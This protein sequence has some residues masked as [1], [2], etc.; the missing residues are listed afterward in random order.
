MQTSYSRHLTNLWQ[1]GIVA[2]LGGSPCLAQA[3]TLNYMAGSAVTRTGTYTDLGTVGTV[4]TT[5]NTDDANS[6]VQTPG[7]VFN[8]NGTAYTSFI[9]NTN[10]FIK[11]GN[12][13]PAAADFITYA[14]DNAGGPV[15][16]P[17][18]T[19]LLMPFNTDLTAGNGGTT[20]YRMSTSGVIPNRVC[21]IQWKNVKDKPRP[22]SASSATLVAAQF[23]NLSFQLKIYETTNNIEFVYGPS[24]AGVASADD[25][26]FVNVGL[27]GSGSG[28]NQVV[29]AQ[30]ASVSSWSVTS[31]LNTAYPTAGNTHNVRG[32]L[33]PDIGRTYTFGVPV[34][35]DAS[36]A[37]IQGFGA[38][39]QPGGNPLSIRAVVRNTGTS[40]LSNLVVS[41]SVSGA[42]S[43]PVMTQTVPTLSSGNSTVVTYTGIRF[44]ANGTNTVTVTVPNDGNLSNNT[45][46]QTLI[47]SPTDFSYIIPSEG[48]YNG[49]GVTPGNESGFAAKFTLNTPRDITAVRAFI[50]DYAATATAGSTI[51]Q[52]VYGVVVDA[53]SG[54]IL[55]RSPN[56]VVT[57][58]AANTL[59]TF[60]L[61]SPVT[62]PAGDF[63]VGMIQIAPASSP[64]FYSMGVQ[65]EDPTRAGIF[66][67]ISG[68]TTSPPSIPLDNS[69]GATL[70]YMLEAVTAPPAT[71][72]TPSAI[73]VSNV[74][75]TAAT[76]SFTGPAN[77]TAYQVV[78][79]L[80]GTTPGPSSISIIGAGSPINLTGLSAGTCYDIYVQSKCG[81]TDQSSLAGPIGVC[82]R[83]APPIIT[84][85][86]YTQN[87]DINSPGQDLACGVTVSDDNVDQNT[88]SAANSVVLSTSTIVVTH[89]NSAF[90]MFYNTNQD[91]ITGA[92]D[93][94]Y[95]P[96]MAFRANTTY[97][98]SFW[99]R[100]QSASLIEALVVRYG[101]APTAAAQTDS[102]YEN[103]NIATRNYLQATNGT[104]PAVMDILP[105]STGTRYIG[106]HALSQAN[107]GFLAVDD[108]NVTAVL[109]TSA[110]MNRAVN[111]YPNPSNTG[112][113][114]LDINGANAQSA[115]QVQVVNMLGQQVYNGLARGNFSNDLNLANLPSGIYSLKVKNGNEYMQQ[116]LSIVK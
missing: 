73:T 96:A 31:F 53:S 61:S 57:A 70:R 13:A 102:I 74:T 113:F 62:M 91:G 43:I 99:Y 15:S 108:V 24:T 6:T 51:G 14:Q 71:C 29:L 11:L 88:W 21:T 4:I 41:L 69:A 66:Y 32:R 3:Q 5:A 90:A 77:G 103:Y 10:G 33:L 46:T 109:A 83:C 9:L 114:K 38:V 56:F 101:S 112:T 98:V 72:P 80:A 17:A 52:S 28:T 104:T 48:L 40:T 42:N 81:A 27:K 87:F 45:L 47:T 111:V 97:R 95:L 100:T 8:Y 116:Q 35:N 49:Y 82:T 68:A 22:A 115:L 93:W 76:V 55:A 30:K 12:T 37:A 20:E 65:R 89:N 23:A 79:A 85:F 75:Q 86:P 107:Q 25:Y 2:I 34:S 26:S 84:A 106:F 110:A 94:F 92:D 18:E 50:T 36:V 63:L 59:H 58:A 78:A 44:T 54:N 67:S 19:D 7:F 16:A 39:L 1:L 60:T 64:I 105:T